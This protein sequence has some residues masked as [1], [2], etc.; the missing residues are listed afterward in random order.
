MDFLYHARH[1]VLSRFSQADLQ[2]ISDSKVMIVGMG[3]TGSAA[4]RLFAGAGISTLALV[5]PD[6]VSLSNIQRQQY[7]IHDVGE[8]KVIAAVKYLKEVNPQVDVTPYDAVFDSDFALSR[9][10]DFDLIYDGT[11]NITTRRIINDICVKT[12]TP[13]VFSSAIETYG[14]FKAIIPGKTS[15]YEC[16][17]PEI[18]GPQQTCSQIGVLNS[19]P[20]T[21][22]S[23]AYALGVRILKGDNVPGDIHFIDA[24]NMNLE[25]IRSARNP[26]CP[27]CSRGD[28]Q[29]LV[30]KYSGFD[31]R[32]VQ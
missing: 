22:A 20:S 15:C 19:V 30:E 12:E 28:F 23:L 9:V 8:K 17:M 29:Y 5:D 31:P 25:K 4:A 6:I 27:V 10:N 14:E 21:V 16:F 2:R 1:L 13:W 7:S 3:G 32:T 26:Q 11:D 18:A 24:W